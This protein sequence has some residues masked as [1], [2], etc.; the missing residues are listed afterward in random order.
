VAV[1]V[2]LAD[3]PQDQ[4]HPL[5]TDQAP[6]FLTTD[7]SSTSTSITAVWSSPVFPLPITSAVV[8]S[9]GAISPTSGSSQP[10]TVSNEP[11]ISPS[12]LPTSATPTP[13]FTASSGLSSAAANAPWI[14]TAFGSVA[15]VAFLLAAFV[16]W[17][18]LRKHRRIRQLEETA[19]ELPWTQLAD[20]L[21]KEQARDAVE[22]WDNIDLGHPDFPPAMPTIPPVSYQNLH[23][24]EA[25]EPTFLLYPLAG[26][27]AADNYRHSPTHSV[28]YRRPLLAKNDNLTRLPT[29]RPSRAYGAREPETMQT[30]SLFSAPDCEPVYRASSHSTA[31]SEL[32]RADS[33]HSFASGASLY[34]RQSRT[35]RGSFTEKEQAARDALKLR[36]LKATTTRQGLAK[37]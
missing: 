16:W 21:E 37:S 3:A 13:S 24:Q 20:E 7:L 2:P 34:S 18:R 10:F 31:V 8:N 15:G 25:D 14:G 23:A 28:N 6:L 33:T 19:D 1:A 30:H 26:L 12:V 32:S 4:V 11:D 22:Q 29:R 9:G 17:C 5:A 27:A 35:R 36:R